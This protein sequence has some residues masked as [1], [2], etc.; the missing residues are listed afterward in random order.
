MGRPQVTA[1]TVDQAPASGAATPRPDLEASL[2]PAPPRPA[3]PDAAPRRPTTRAGRKAA[4]LARAATP[5][6]DK[7]PKAAKAT[8]RR[9]PLEQRLSQ[10]LVGLGT[11]VAG[12][13]SAVSPAVT[14]DGV[15]IVQSAPDI[16]A[17]LDRI[18]KDD[19]RVAAALE[20]MLT[21][22]VWSGL[23]TALV[24]LAVGIAANHGVLPASLVAILAGQA[25]PAP[26]VPPGA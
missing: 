11:I 20:R 8:P 9:A 19:P 16:A 24:P 13:G 14:A 15:L 3:E 26:E 23:I 12:V 10:N 1:G 18:A 4:A 2:P 22:G 7:A 17:A 25:E 5:K 6:A 21:A